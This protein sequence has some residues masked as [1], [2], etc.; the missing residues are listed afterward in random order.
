[1][2]IA[3]SDLDTVQAYK[4]LSGIVVPRPIAWITTRSSPTVVNLAPFSCFTFVSSNPPMVGF[5]VGEKV[6][7]LKDTP[8]NIKA[9]GEYVVNIADDTMI[10]Q[11]HSSSGDFPSHESE[12][13][14]LGLATASSD[15]IDCPR[16]RDVP[17][18]M[19]CRFDSST[20][21]GRGKSQFIV[22][23]IVCF[24]IRDDLYDNGKINTANLRPICRIAGPHYA[25]L[26]PIVT[27]ATLGTFGPPAR[28][29]AGSKLSRSI[30][31]VSGIR[32]TAT[33]SSRPVVS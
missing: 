30:R 27:Q 15:F 26:G 29:T 2:K 7:G 19:E 3:S 21:F 16:L 20:R 17:V 12:I 18:S 4:L 14:M 10:D 33:S 25:S 5:N 22:G 8:T 32:S 31:R 13:D 1:M 23:E 11:V 28:S 6:S 9:T 24:H